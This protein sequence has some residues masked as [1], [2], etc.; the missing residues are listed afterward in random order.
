MKYKVIHGSYQ[1]IEQQLNA[2][3]SKSWHPITM[4]NMGVGTATFV[5]ILEK[6]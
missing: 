3:D 2:L 5:V 4:A 1:E 6:V